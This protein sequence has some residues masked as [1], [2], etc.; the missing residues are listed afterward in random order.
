MAPATA[1]RVVKLRCGILL[2]PLTDVP[3]SAELADEL[4]QWQA[5]SAEAWEM[6]DPWDPS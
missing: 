5:L 6:I 2:V 1:I 3:V 4:A